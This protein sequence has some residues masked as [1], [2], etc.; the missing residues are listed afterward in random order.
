V[1]ALAVTIDRA[2]VCIIVLKW[3]PRD[4]SP[5]SRASR[6]DLGDF[7]HRRRRQ[8]LARRLGGGDPR[9]LPRRDGAA[10]P[11]EPGVR[12]RQQ[13]VMRLALEHGAETVLV[14]CGRSS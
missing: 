3:N 9:A 5:V 1:R 12:G 6:A 4:P 14:R 10:A 13:R 11:E 8:R 2:R 7:P